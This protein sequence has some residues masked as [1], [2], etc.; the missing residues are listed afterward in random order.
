MGIEIEVPKKLWPF[1]AHGVQFHNESGDELIGICPFCTGRKLYVNRRTTQ[2]SCKNCGVSGNIATFL[3]GIVDIH[4][5]DTGPKH[6]QSL[7][8]LRGLPTWIFHKFKLSYDSGRNRWLLPCQSITGTVRDIR[9]WN[10]KNKKLMCTRGCKSQLYNAVAFNKGGGRGRGI[11]WIVEGE[12]DVLALY[13]LLRGCGRKRRG[14]IVVGL[15]G[16]ETFK[17]EWIEYFT[18]RRVRVCLDNDAVG[19]RGADKIRRLIGGVVS[20]IKYLC[21]PESLCRGYDVRDYVVESRGLDTGAATALK[22]LR[23]LMESVPRHGEA[24]MDVGGVNEGVVGVVGGR[25]RRKFDVVPKKDRP[26]FNEVVRVLGK[27]IEVDNELIS[28]LRYILAIIF[29]QQLGGN[30]LWGYVIGPPGSGKT[31]LLNMT[32][33]SDRTLF[34]S[35]VGPHNLVSGF[36]A[37]HDPS[38]ISHVNGLVLIIKDGTQLLTQPLIVK[39]EVFSILRDAYD[40]SLHRQ[41]GNGVLREYEDLHFSVC[42]GVTPIVNGMSEATLGDRF[43]KFQIRALGDSNLEDRVGSAIDVVSGIEVEKDIQIECND[44]VRRFLARRVGTFPVVPSWAK[45]RLVPLSM[46]VAALRSGVDKDR[47]T[48]ELLYEP[49]IEYGTRIAKQLTKLLRACAVVSGENNISRKTYRFVERVAY[50]TSIRYHF[51]IV[52]CI[53]MLGGR[54]DKGEIIEVLGIPSTT[55]YRHLEDMLAL[56]ILRRARDIVSGTGRPGYVWSVTKRIKSLWKRCRP[57]AGIRLNRI[58]KE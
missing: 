34:K 18:G 49:E 8:K 35:S 2:Y 51:D 11:V 17:E 38:L 3:K 9:T 28:T 7:S 1:E 46:L 30:P 48:G 10:P 47:F 31:L 26:S 58:G 37:K 39:Q 41:F 16:G 23:R 52:S 29:S 32:S 43:V 6:Y 14:D 22:R 56:K 53:M 20:G 27:Y 54:V 4:L 50:D 40:G 13:V 42:I 24:V 45:D 36:K 33:T 55:L 12:W 57:K 44:V 5:E 21:W 19:D 15:P 25:K